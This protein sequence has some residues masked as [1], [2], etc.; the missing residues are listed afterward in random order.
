MRVSSHRM[1]LQAFQTFAIGAYNI[2]TMEQVIGLFRGCELSDA[3]FVLA[4]YPSTQRYAGARM[5]EAIIMQAERE[6]PNVVFGVNLDHGDEALCYDAIDSGVYTSVMIDAS[7]EPFAKN[8]EISRRVVEYAHARGVSVEGMVGEI[9]GFEKHMRILPE[10]DVLLTDPK[11][12]ERYLAETGC[13]VLA[14]SIGSRHGHKKAEGAAR[15]VDLGRL[16]EIAAAVPGVPLVMHGGSNI[17]ADEV[18]RV[19]AAGGQLGSA[20]GMDAQEQATLHRFGIAQVNVSSDS[21]LIWS[22]VHREFF[23]DHPDRIDLREAGARF[24]DDYATFIARKNATLGSAGRLEEIKRA[25]SP[26]VVPPGVV[27]PDREP[28]RTAGQVPH[29]AGRHTPVSEADLVGQE[30]IEMRNGA[31]I[32]Q[33]SDGR[34]HVVSHFAVPSIEA[35]RSAIAPDARQVASEVPQSTGTSRCSGASGEASSALLGA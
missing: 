5:L 28:S 25:L 24:I 7:A 20:R 26:G 33:L 12:A 35:A 11:Q 23:R 2:H 10:S 18:A 30:F 31:V 29:F 22:R 34:Y 4:V 14:V 21:F 19:N 15:V 16:A 32:F 3:P 9:G 27:P 1:M 13:D 17:P 6:F 8:V